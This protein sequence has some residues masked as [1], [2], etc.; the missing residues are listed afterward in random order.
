MRPNKLLLVVLSLASL[1]VLMTTTVFAAD[2]GGY[3]VNIEDTEYGSVSSAQ[4]SYAPGETVTLTVTPDSGYGLRR[5]EL[6]CDVSYLVPARTGIDT[7]TFTMPE[8]D[9]TVNAFFDPAVYVIL[10]FGEKHQGYAKQFADFYGFEVSGARVTVTLAF[11]GEDEK[12]PTVYA[13]K[14][15]LV[16]YLMWFLTDSETGMI[17]KERAFDEGEHLHQLGDSTVGLKPISEYSEEKELS[18]ESWDA[19]GNYV[20]LSEQPVFYAIWEQKYTGTATVT[21]TP[22][23]IG[24]EIAKENYGSIATDHSEPEPVVTVTGLELGFFNKCWFSSY[25][26][27]TGQTSGLFTGEI[28]PGTDYYTRAYAHAPFGYYIEGAESFITV[29]GAKAYWI[30]KSQNSEAEVCIWACVT[31]AEPTYHSLS[32]SE[33]I[34]NGL[35]SIGDKTTAYT[36][37]LVYVDVII[38]E[39]YVLKRI[40]CKGNNGQEETEIKRAGEKYRFNMPDYDSTIYAEIIPENMVYVDFGEGHENFAGKLFGDIEGFTVEG[41]V[42]S[43]QFVPTEEDDS[44]AAAIRAFVDAVNWTDVDLEDNGVKLMLNFGLHTFDYYKTA[45]DLENESQTTNRMSVKESVTFYA[46][47]IQPATD[48]TITIIPPACNTEVVYREKNSNAAQTD[49]EPVITVSG[50]CHKL[51][52][53]VAYENWDLSAYGTYGI[54]DPPVVM[55]GGNT[56]TATGYLSPNWGFYI[57][58]NLADSIQVV[59][60]T[61]KFC[62]NDYYGIDVTIEHVIPEDAVRVEP[63]C[64]KPGSLSYVCPNCKKEVEEELEMLPHKLSKTDAVAPTCTEAG[65]IE[66]YNCGQC[67]GFFADENGEKPITESNGSVTAQIEI[68]A[69]GH[70]WGNPTYK[71]AEDLS[72]VTATRICGRDKTHTETETVKTVAKV[73]KEATATEAGERTYTA[74]FVNPAF[75]TQTGKETIPATGD[76]EETGKNPIS[77]TSES[78]NLVVEWGDSLS[79]SVHRSENDE[80]CIQYYRE[81]R[82][83]GKAVNS[84]TKK[85]STIVTVDADTL[86]GIGAGKHT[87]SVVFADGVFETEYTLREAS[88]PDES[89]PES[90]K[91]ADSTPVVVLFILLALSA[92]G[93]VFCRVCRGKRVA[94]RCDRD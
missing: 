13:A 40:Y 17:I 14:A 89:A 83:N 64:T 75:A 86:Q 28:K 87:I 38:D 37:E 93:M 7:F 68:K 6:S 10:D 63:T 25:D 21:F 3:S 16:D 20:S 77:Y 67:N 22:P 85:G 35:V 15:K 76:A 71:W 32:V 12:T 91:T 43:F 90:P 9:V 55:I 94:V 31:S 92:A 34:E 57:P 59:G 74:E 33:D 80:E 73:T 84:V 66:Y 19:N 18:G 29:N 2:A 23:V 70:D 56:Y 69:L 4:E 30:Q 72:S 24:M 49:P 26:P 11:G 48:V 60:G 41:S 61:L 27:Q 79:F 82:I 39:A 78:G 47:W 88:Q 58:D 42:V 8:G 52:L 45:E 50:G 65:N 5:L 51:V 62:R 44:A 36:G 81:T 53:P 1:L 54:G 46:L